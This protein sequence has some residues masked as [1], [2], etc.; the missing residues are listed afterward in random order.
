MPSSPLHARGLR[1]A[2]TQLTTAV[3]RWRELRFLSV[4]GGGRRTP[5]AWGR[6]SGGGKDCCGCRR[7]VGGGR[8]ELGSVLTAQGLVNDPRASGEA[9]TLDTRPESVVAT[10]RR[11]G[12]EG[13]REREPLP[14]QLSLCVFRHLPPLLISN[15]GSPI[16]GYRA[17]RSGVREFAA[18]KHVSFLRRLVRASPSC[19][20]PWFASA[21]SSR[22]MYTRC[23]S[24][25]TWFE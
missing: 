4:V 3:D 5:G 10:W 20:F 7:C 22:R 21:A 9:L 25:G 13:E 2:H 23:N 11:R 12:E 14:Y 17:G 18:N 24:S 1:P 16:S 15:S 19:P 8:E 6:E